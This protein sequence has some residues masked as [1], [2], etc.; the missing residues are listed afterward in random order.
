M[1]TFFSENWFV[2][3][4]TTMDLQFTVWKISRKN[5]ESKNS[6]HNEGTNVKFFKKSGIIGIEPV[7]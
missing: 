3:L 1:F 6:V 4:T 2:A 7:R 5:I